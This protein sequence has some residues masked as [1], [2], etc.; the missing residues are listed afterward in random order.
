MRL[1]AH[2]RKMAARAIFTAMAT[3]VMAGGIQA[4]VAATPAFAART[5]PAAA[6]S[7]AGHTATT[8]G[9]MH[10][11][12]LHSGY[13]HALAHVKHLGKIAGITYRIGYRPKAAAAKATAACAEPNC[14]L[15]YNGGPVEHTVHIYLLL[16]GPAWANRTGE[17]RTAAYMKSFYQGLGVQPKDTW[18]LT[19]S[20]YTDSTGF[21]TFSGSQYEGTFTDTSTPPFGTTQTQLQA[22]ADAFATAH[23]LTTNPQDDQV[24]I[25]TQSGT[26]PQGFYAPNCFGGTGSYCAYHS[27]DPY[28]GVTYTN[29]PYLLDAGTGCGENFV[30]SGSAGYRDG[31]SIVGGHEYAETITDPYPFSGWIDLNDGV[32]GGEIGDKCAW[33]G[34]LWGSSDPAGDV[35]LSTGTFAMQS[36]W[37]NAANRCVMAATREDKVS[38]TNPGGQST[39]TGSAASLQ[40]MASSSA[41][42]RPELSYAASGLPAGLSI[43]SQTG[44]ITGTPTGDANNTVTVR[45]F[46]TTGASGSTSFN[47]TTGPACQPAQL[48]GNPGFESGRLYPWH[49]TRGVLTRSSRQYPARSGKWLAMLQESIPRHTNYL[50]QEV[51]IAA[52]CAN[53]R[54]SFWLRVITNAPR[55]RIWARLRVEILSP[56]GRVL[57]LLRTFTNR[58]AGHYQYYYFNTGSYAGRRIVVE[59]F[60]LDNLRYRT[61]SFLIDNT[62]LVVS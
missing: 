47:W 28:S 20:Q 34:K 57:A 32:S 17:I 4:A 49:A 29:M 16:W 52:G 40:I 33:G 55:R 18:S 12:N 11:T 25:A 46:D 21:P 50:S 26:C 31:F 44:L 13:E 2:R 8:P 3:L 59:F 51:T 43:D 24:I 35:K 6:T 36:L 7:H 62:A 10:L 19:T 61:T 1:H 5:A 45:V 37:S 42:P 38:V 54:L 56:R 48:L 58:N 27:N 23:N 60:G 9:W 41:S 53:A 30:N 22:E 15:A 14:K 39:I